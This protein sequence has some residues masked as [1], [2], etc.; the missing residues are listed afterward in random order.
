[1][2]TILGVPKGAVSFAFEDA[3][4]VEEK[5]TSP[6]YPGVSTVYRKTIVFGKTFLN[7]KPTIM[8]GD[9]QE[10]FQS[11]GPKGESKAWSWLSL[12]DLKSKKIKV[13][14]GKKE[15][16]QMSGLVLAGM[17]ME[18]EGLKS[19]L[20]EHNINARE[21]YG[22]GQAKTLFEFAQ[23]I[24]RGESY[25][26]SENGVLTRVVDVVLLKLEDPAS[27]KILLETARCNEKT[28]STKRKDQ[29]PGAKARPNENIYAT[30]RRICSILLGLK[31][32]YLVFGAHTLIEEESESSGYPGMLTCYRKHIIDARLEKEGH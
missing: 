13:P 22:K 3:E 28:G 29:L 20:E 6:S 26:Q 31:D 17:K 9:K 8:G 1:M 14:E 10:S 16:E 2:K 15:S 24:G 19:L 32:D 7:S 25:L 27:K 18:E 30:A 11:T 12:K 4:I 23:E 21:M 5:E